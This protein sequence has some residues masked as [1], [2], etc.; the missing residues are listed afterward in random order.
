MAD[1]I[2]SS[3]RERFKNGDRT[4]NFVFC[5]VGLVIIFKTL[6]LGIRIYQEP[7]WGD[8]GDYLYNYSGGF[9]RRGLTGEI[10]IFLKERFSASPLMVCYVTSIM[11]YA[12]V[13]YYVLS[14]FR[15]KGLGPA[16][17][18]TGFT[19]GSVF[20]FG[21]APMRRDY[22]ELALFIAIIWSYRRLKTSQWLVLSNIIAILGILLHEAT[23]FFMV[24]VCILL[25]VTRLHGIVKACAAW[26]P[27]IIA[28]AICCIYKGDAEM[29]VRIVDAAQALAPDAFA[30][31]AVPGALPYI[32]KSTDEVFAFHIGMN[33]TDRIYG[34]PLPVGIVTVFYFVY[35]PFITI[36][37]LKVFSRRSPGARRLGAL[38]SLIGF[39]FIF[40][41]PMFTV[42]SC[43]ICRVCLY[44]VMSS[45]IVWLT[46]GEED[47]E[48]LFGDRYN[49]L[50]RKTVVGMLSPRV[51]RSKILLAFCVLFIGVTFY[52]RQP[53]DMALS[54]PAGSAVWTVT[55]VF[56]KVRPHI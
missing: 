50:C 41:L 27:S 36:A 14:K 18:I 45:L 9:I 23:F 10:L 1:N 13:A 5:A 43:D 12:I 25:T 34:L 53:M 44:W 2:L 42:L 7:Y 52:R 40:L 48:A 55:Q 15:T 51:A 33:F 39:Q 29:Y 30:G 4:Y 22:I 17:L 47:V 19:L 37:A 8:F 21:F 26:L 46:L 49:Q 3:H 6:F 11:G 20:I 56:E 35:V 32:G 16:I 54:S 24:P 28:F 38:L 31:G